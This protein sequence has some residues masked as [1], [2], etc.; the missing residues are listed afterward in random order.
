MFENK[1]NALLKALELN[2]DTCERTIVF[3][4]TIDQ[5]RRVENILQREVR[6]QGLLVTCQITLFG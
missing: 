5:C 2:A 6:P 1:K 4:N 3:C